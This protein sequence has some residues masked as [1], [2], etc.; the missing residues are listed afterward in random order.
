MSYRYHISAAK[1][2]KQKNTWKDS[3]ES[4]NGCI[5]RFRQIICRKKSGEVS[6]KTSRYWINYVKMINIF[7]EYS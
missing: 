1:H 5:I 6:G 7:H 3:N 4:R 2:D